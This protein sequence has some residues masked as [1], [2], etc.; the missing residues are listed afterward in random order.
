MTSRAGTLPDAGGE[1]IAHEFDYSKTAVIYDENGV[2]V[3]SIPAVPI[4][5]LLFVAARAACSNDPSVLA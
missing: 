1:I 5:D 4:R 2:K 3:T